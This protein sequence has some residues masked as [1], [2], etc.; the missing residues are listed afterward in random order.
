MFFGRKRGLMRLVAAVS[1]AVIVLPGVLQIYLAAVP[2]ES[3]QTLLAKLIGAIP[4]GNPISRAVS[5]IMADAMSGGDSLLE[6][7]EKG[8]FSMEQF[9]SLEMGK[10]LFS[11]AIL[12]A[13]LRV[14]E[15]TIWDQKLRG[16]LNR[17]ADVVFL[18]VFVFV[19]GL[20]A[21]MLFS[22]AEKLVL[23]SVGILRSIA[24]YITSGA[25][26]VGGIL[27]LCVTGLAFTK[28]LLTVGMNCLKMIFTYGG[29]IWV[30]L[31][32]IKEV[33]HPVLL[34]G[35]VAWIGLIG[36]LLVA[37]ELILN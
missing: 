10:M 1:L 6:W 3:P 36:L 37:E 35:I 12:S 19:S 28:A 23:Q 9:F 33:S 31:C 29:I 18:T 7:M 24:V 5:G 27:L 32:I 22:F 14:L 17:I 34:A 30:L 8:D 13:I 4:F 26:S 2:G 21:E 15:N 11:A 25:L 20:L 16:I